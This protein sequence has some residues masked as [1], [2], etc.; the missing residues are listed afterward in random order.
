MRGKPMSLKNGSIIFRIKGFN[1]LCQLKKQIYFALP[2]PEPK[3]AFLVDPSR[4]WVGLFIDPN[5]G[6]SAPLPP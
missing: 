6:L 4:G 5:L 3:K 2:I 1:I